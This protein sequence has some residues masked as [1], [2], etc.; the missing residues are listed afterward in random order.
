MC[1]QVLRLARH[2]LGLHLQ[3]QSALAHQEA[4][5]GASA[6]R[7]R[8]R[9]G[10]DTEGVRGA[11][12]R[13]DGHGRNVDRGAA[14]HVGGTEHDRPVVGVVRGGGDVGVHGEVAAGHHGAL[15]GGGRPG[16]DRFGVDDGAFAR[17]G[18]VIGV[19]DRDQEDRGLLGEREA[20]FQ[21]LLIGERPTVEQLHAV[22]I[23][24]LQIA[25]E[26]EPGH[27]LA[28]RVWRVADAH[29]AADGRA[30]RGGEHLD[31]AGDDTLLHGH[32]LFGAHAAG[33]HRVAEVFGPDVQIAGTDVESV[34]R[35]LPVIEHEGGA[36]RDRRCVDELERPQLHLSAHRPIRGGHL[37]G[38]GGRGVAEL[39]PPRVVG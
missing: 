28:V 9:V 12:V 20:E 4:G 34:E 13:A 37:T 15:C 32:P 19:I 39:P 14:D 31:L 11:T 2:K 25:H 10:R 36:E 1:L 33:V 16:R 22:R 27:G 26:R 21:R 5:A 24:H 29:I 17:G 6:R 7:V 8:I 18:P 30:P 35:E 38:D 3:C 23:D